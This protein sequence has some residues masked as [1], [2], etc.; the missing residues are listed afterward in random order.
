MTSTDQFEDRLLRELQAVVSAQPAAAAPTSH[1]LRNRLA[2]G[3]GTVAAATAGA[4]AL[5][6][7]STPAYAVSD[8]DGT[9]TVT[10]SSLKDAA[11]LQHAL[12]ADG[13]QAAV[14]YTPA[15]KMCREPRGQ[16]PGGSGRMSGSVDTT[17]GGATTFTL[18]PG[19]VGVDETLV[20]ETSV[21]NQVSSIGISVIKGAVSPCVLVTSTRADGGGPTTQSGSGPSQGTSSKSG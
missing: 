4:V 7:G 11:G 10:I 20:I 6:A 21:G 19:Q 16:A 15:G 18:T 3:A 5:T 13:V 8:H 17:R 14:D 9:V 2:V 12:Q 1:R